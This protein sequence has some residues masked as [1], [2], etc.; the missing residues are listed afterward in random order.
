[1][2]ETVISNCGCCTQGCFRRK[3]GICKKS[4]GEIGEYMELGK[5]CTCEQF[6]PP[7]HC[8]P[9]ADGSPHYVFNN[10]TD[11]RVRIIEE[12]T[13]HRPAQVLCTLPS[14]RLGDPLDDNRCRFGGG[15]Y[16]LENM[17]TRQHYYGGIIDYG[18]TFGCRPYNEFCGYLEHYPDSANTQSSLKGWC[19][20]YYAG[21]KNV[22]ES[23]SCGD[24]GGCLDCTINTTPY[25]VYTTDVIQITLFHQPAFYRWILQLNIGYVKGRYVDY[26]P[27][28]CRDCTVFYNIDEGDFLCKGVN[29]LTGGLRGHGPNGCLTGYPSEEDRCRNDMKYC[30]ELPTSVTIEVL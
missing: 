17:V 23:D 26:Y 16:I 18:T 2:S 15:T 5:C 19:A 21:Y 27:I 11:D 13:S 1:M 28:G 22:T 3:C 20:F 6:N 12:C 30:G 24:G 9:N 8:T 10:C 25:G 29:I 14:I 4:T 7:H